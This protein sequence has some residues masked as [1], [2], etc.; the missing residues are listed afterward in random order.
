MEDLL[1]VQQG[2]QI[3]GCSVAQA[4]LD[5][6][7]ALDGADTTLTELGWLDRDVAKGSLGSMVPSPWDSFVDRYRSTL[8]PI[9]VE[10]GLE[11]AELISIVDGRQPLGRMLVHF[12]FRLD[13]T[14][15]GRR[16][17]RPVSP[18]LKDGP[19]SWGSDSPWSN[20]LTGSP[21][22]LWSV[23]WWPATTGHWLT[24]TGST[25]TRLTSAGADMLELEPLKPDDTAVFASMVVGRTN[26]RRHVHGHGEPIGPDGGRP[27]RGVVVRSN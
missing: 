5:R 9:T 1:P 20:A 8:D 15:R 11:L 13:N 4:E 22:F 21:S 7:T 26:G 12:D 19:S 25:T 16:A 18:S 17:G 24:T 3:V 23:I 10:T 27:R 14:P 2:D 6:C